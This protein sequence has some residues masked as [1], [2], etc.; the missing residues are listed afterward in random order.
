MKPPIDVQNR[1]PR[2]GSQRT[3]LVSIVRNDDMKLRRRDRILLG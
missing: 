3:E 2:P 1:C